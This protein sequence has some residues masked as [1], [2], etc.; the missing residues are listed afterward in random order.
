MKN[1]WKRIHHR[2]V[3]IIQKQTI[4]FYMWE[5]S[6]GGDDNLNVIFYSNTITITT[7]C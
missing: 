4:V 2:R 5:L 3:H 7:F 1:E 6:E